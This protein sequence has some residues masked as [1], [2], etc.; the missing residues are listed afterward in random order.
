M[1]HTFERYFDA[2]TRVAVGKYI[3]VSL[4]VYCMVGPVLGWALGVGDLFS[5]YMV[6]IPATALIAAPVS[7]IGVR[8]GQQVERANDALARQQVDL[9]DA[10]RRAEKEAAAK[11]DFLAVMSH[12]IRTPLNG[13]LGIAQVL[14][15]RDLP[16]AE[17]ALALQIL[18][19]GDALMRIL[20]D[21]LD[22]SKIDAG[23]LSIAPIVVDPV[24]E[25]EAVGSL[26]AAMAARKGLC[27]ELDY[28]RDFPARLRFD[29]H[30]MRQCLGNL[31]SN[32]I[33]F[34]D[35]GG[36]SV[37]IKG[38][39]RAAGMAEIRIDVA[40]TGLGMD[41]PALEAIFAPFAQGA[42]PATRSYGGTGLGL[43]IS[44]R[45]ARLMGGD[46][47]A[48]STPDF[49][50]VFTF[51]FIAEV[52][53]AETAE[54][55]AEETEASSAHPSPPAQRQAE[56]EAPA[57]QAAT[58]TAKQTATRAA[59]P[60]S[61]TLNAGTL[62]AGTVKPASAPQDGPSKFQAPDPDA[63]PVPLHEMDRGRMGAP[64]P[65]RRAA[66]APAPAPAA[67][68]P[69]PAPAAVAPIASLKAAPTRGAVAPHP[70]S[71][72]PG[73]RASAPEA[74]PLS[75]RRVL[76]VDDVA[77]NRT[78]VRLLLEPAGALV[79]EAKDGSEALEIIDKCDFDVV[80]L[81]SHMPVL[82]GQQTLARLRKGPS[83]ATPV[84]A[85][86]A[87]AMDGDRERFLASGM[88]GYI[89]KPVD[90]ETLIGEVSR[91]VGGPVVKEDDDPP[92]ALPYGGRSA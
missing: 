13:V 10:R 35:E 77:T 47:V 21:T 16:E 23:E 61:G 5:I 53:E 28:G 85:F 49:G 32:A 22:M 56:I 82:N 36:V 43:T 38:R 90:A 42:A 59:K 62:N 72:Q 39:H 41:A 26:F 4:F 69:A 8:H 48:S 17:R 44:R 50:S 80:L 84:I 24:T 75:A 92:G 78:V 86:T 74:P 60:L 83:R 7:W 29:P 27:F 57:P 19:S 37:A 89:S 40:D 30:R 6:G 67:V 46:V 81:D 2:D 1:N 33:K 34:T 18:E 71:I 58:Q 68:A 79:S 73:R 11:A 15:D 64:R 52:V 51:S 65:A 3:A 63:P 9:I 25:F 14:A 12:E 91:V 87:E 54:Q 31:I 88:E 55:A 70:S 66:D 20:N 45:I 76:I